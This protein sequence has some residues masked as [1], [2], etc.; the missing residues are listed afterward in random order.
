MAYPPTMSEARMQSQREFIESRIQTSKQFDK[1][2]LTLVDPNDVIIASTTGELRNI[3]LSFF[4]G[5]PYSEKKCEHCETTTGKQ[6]ERAHA[7]GY[8]RSDVALAALKRIRP[9]ETQHIKQKEF[10]KAFIEEHARV[11]LWYLCKECHKRY[12]KST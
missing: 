4:K 6:Y 7:R 11:P 8:S 12:D 10:I 1:F 2:G 9:D 5:G 3:I